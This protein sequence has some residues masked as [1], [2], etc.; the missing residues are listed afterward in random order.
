MARNKDL[1]SE[2]R[3][4]MLVLRN[5][6]YSMEIIK[7]LKISVLGILDEKRA[8]IKLPATQP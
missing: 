4:S 1:S 3:Q 8:Q 7:K 6:G 5:E 2:T